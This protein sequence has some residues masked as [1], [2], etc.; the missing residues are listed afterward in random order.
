MDGHLEI[1]R[2]KNDPSGVAMVEFDRV[3]AVVEHHDI[4]SNS[5]QS[6]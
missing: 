1:A 2:V 4:L 3:E 5:K 6:G